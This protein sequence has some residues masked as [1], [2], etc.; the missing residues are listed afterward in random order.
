MTQRAADVS[1]AICGDADTDARTANQ[2]AVNAVVYV[3]SSF[4]CGIAVTF[5]KI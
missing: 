1:V 4:K 5:L 2:N 3:K